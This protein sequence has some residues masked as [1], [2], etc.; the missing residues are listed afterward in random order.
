MFIFFCFKQK[1]AYEMRISEWSYDVCSSDLP[2]QRIAGCGGLL[3][4]Q[5]LCMIHHQL[6]Q[7]PDFPGQ[8]FIVAQYLGRNSVEQI[9][10]A[11]C[12]ERVCEYEYIS[13]VGVSL[14]INNT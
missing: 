9:G 5:V 12:R 6:F 13:V 1:T 10:R 4:F 14:N 3:E 8:R 2:I 7:T 11:S